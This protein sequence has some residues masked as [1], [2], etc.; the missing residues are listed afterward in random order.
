[1]LEILES[2]LA[3]TRQC[4]RHFRLATGTVHTMA[5]LTLPAAIKRMGERQLARVACIARDLALHRN[6]ADLSASL[7]PPAAAATSSPRRAS[8]RPGAPPLAAV[9]LRCLS[10]RDLLQPVFALVAAEAA[11]R[12][13][14]EVRY[15]SLS[16]VGEILEAGR[17]WRWRALPHRD[18]QA[19]ASLKE[20]TAAAL[21][22]LQAAV[23][24]CAAPEAGAAGVPRASAWRARPPHMQNL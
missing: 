15:V 23:D 7:G 8:S 20:A 24:E 11:W 13:S 4:S 22:L 10:P 19:L 21:A 1:M 9:G 2:W 17:A 12:A 14:N 6:E 3:I 18:S 16:T 5:T